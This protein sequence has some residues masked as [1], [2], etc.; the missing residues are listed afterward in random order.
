M[1]RQIRERDGFMTRTLEMWKLFMERTGKKSIGDYLL[2]GNLVSE[3]LFDYIR[4]H[5]PLETDTPNYVQL[6]DV[7][8]HCY[9][10]G[11][12]L[13]PV[14]PTFAEYDTQW[15]YYG[16]CYKWETINRF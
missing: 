8:G 13:R 12:V 16:N 1:H 9:D 10:L 2:V 14:F 3:D 4:N 7:Q 5:M 15:R 11:L 6:D